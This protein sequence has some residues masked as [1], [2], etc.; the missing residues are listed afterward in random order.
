M[1]PLTQAFAL[2]TAITTAITTGI[3]ADARNTA[4]M[5]PEQ[6]VRYWDIRLRQM[7]VLS[8]VMKPLGDVI[9]K[10]ADRPRP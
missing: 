2:A 10:L 8:A 3:E 6:Q 4:T 1:D 5:S 7:D 9:L